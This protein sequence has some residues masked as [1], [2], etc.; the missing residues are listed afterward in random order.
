M[1]STDVV[2]LSLLNQRPDV[3]LLQVFNL[4]LVGGSK[5]SDQA[6]IVASNDNT[7]L[8]SGLSVIDAVFRVDASLLAGLSQCVGVLVAAD[9]ADVKNGVLRKYV[10][11]RL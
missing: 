9:T 3:R 7:A 2:D 5:V 6:T 1:E 4:V 10:L 8:S 11:V